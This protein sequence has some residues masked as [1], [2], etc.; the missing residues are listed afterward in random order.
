MWKSVIF[1]KCTIVIDNACPLDTSVLVPWVQYVDFLAEGDDTPGGNQTPNPSSG[2]MLCATLW[3]RQDQLLPI[4]SSFFI[5][6][7]NSKPCCWFH[8]WWT[9]SW[10]CGAFSPFIFSA[11]VIFFLK[12][13]PSY[14]W[15]HQ[16]FFLLQKSNTVIVMLVGRVYPRP[17][18]SMFVH[19]CA[20]LPW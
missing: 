4:I 3:G 5:L 19:I 16:L 7:W 18:Y 1:I 2:L 12:C 15:C 20:V 13:L 17:T 10:P 14:W 11:A 9:L 6:N 8:V